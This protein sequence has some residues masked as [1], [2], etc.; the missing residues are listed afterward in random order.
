[1]LILML[2]T[3]VME[4]RAGVCHHGRDYR[5]SDPVFAGVGMQRQAKY[6]EHYLGKVTT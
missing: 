4:K 2:H 6:S 3:Y 5:A 1:M